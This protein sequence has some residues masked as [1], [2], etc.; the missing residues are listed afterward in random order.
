MA[1]AIVITKT[2]QAGTNYSMGR[3]VYAVTIN[4]SNE[5]IY[6]PN[7]PLFNV[8]D[9]AL[10][11]AKEQ[12]VKASEATQAVTVTA[13]ALD[14]TLKTFLTAKYMAESQFSGVTFA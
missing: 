5:G 2:V 14:A 9:K 3:E 4:G 12:A 1:K 6:L 10:A 13:P 7:Q 11:V 8:V